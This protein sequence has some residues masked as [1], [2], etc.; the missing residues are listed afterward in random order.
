MNLRPQGQPSRVSALRWLEPFRARLRKKTS[1]FLILFVLLPACTPQEPLPERRT[2]SVTRQP[3][4][5]WTSFTGTLEAQTRETVFSRI[6]EPTTVVW[7]APEGSV[8]KKGD[9]IVKFDPDPLDVSLSKAKQDVST[10]SAMFTRLTQG[11]HPLQLMAVEQE[12]QAV[13]VEAERA[14]TV[15]EQSVPLQAEGLLS[16]SEVEDLRNRSLALHQSVKNTERRYQVL[17]EILHPAE[18]GEAEA[19]LEQAKRR[20]EVL[21]EQDAATELRAGIG[22]MV[23]RLPL[24]IGG[25]YRT[26]R[27]GDT[28]FRNQRFMQVADLQ[29]LRAQF[30]VPEDQISRVRNGNSAVVIPSAFPDQDLHA[31]IDSV[32]AVALSSPGAPAWRK[33]FQVTAKLNGT[34]LP[35]RSGM[36]VRVMILSHSDSNALVV[37]RAFVSWSEGLPGV[38]SLQE[39]DE[40]WSPITILAGNES[41]FSIQENELEGASI[42]EPSLP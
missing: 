36:T 22:G 27:E 14:R 23:M 1:G 31:E 11:E 32:A 17:K 13:K 16:P 30:E 9:V 7:M 15:L 35:L 39:Q 38:W 6:S 19:K 21:S 42:L 29:T 34:L 40:V 24:H 26:L 2:V 12:L 18:K 8:V 5:V 3:F 4:A 20:L 41:G 37:P 25:E 10:A 28:V 33:T